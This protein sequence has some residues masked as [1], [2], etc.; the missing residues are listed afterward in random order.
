MIENIL[1]QVRNSPVNMPI[2]LLAFLPVLP[3]FTGESA[4]ADEAQWQMNAD[5]L[6]T[7]FDLVLAQLQQV[8]QERTVM[9]CRDGKTRL[10]FP[11]Y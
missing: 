10:G 8:V 1:S 6:Q 7:V 9:N 11:I 2:L 4:R 5:V 3:K